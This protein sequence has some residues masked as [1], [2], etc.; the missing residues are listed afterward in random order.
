MKLDNSDK[1]ILYFSSWFVVSQNMSLS[2]E[3]DGLYGGG[4]SA[5][6]IKCEDF[7]GNTSIWYLVEV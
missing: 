7:D 4:G 1:Y 6:N 3:S 5:G 2:D